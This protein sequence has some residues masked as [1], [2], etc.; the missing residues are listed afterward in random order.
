M[1]DYI[2][3][4]IKAGITLDVPVSLTAYPA[5]EWQMRLILRGPQGVDLLAEQDGDAHRLLASAETTGAWLPGDYWASLRVSDGYEVVE[6]EAASVRVSAD[7]AQVEG[8]Y[9]G[10]GHVQRV[11][12]SIEAVIE[13]RATK[14]QARYKI[15]NRE[16][17]RTPISDLLALRDK[18]KD[19][20]RRERA[21]AKGQTLLGRR[22]LVR[23]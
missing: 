9:D 1:T 18:Y 2:P 15:N 6:V 10:R 5:G 7:L 20:A 13:G 8:V 21:A 3:R 14:D 16:L 4:Q 23:F 19:E 11:L 17:E 22:V 12:A